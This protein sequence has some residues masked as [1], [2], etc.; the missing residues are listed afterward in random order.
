QD[1][2]WL[3]YVTLLKKAGSPTYPSRS[4]L[5]LLAIWGRCR[6]SSGRHR[7]NSGF[8]PFLRSGGAV[9]QVWIMAFLQDDAEAMSAGSNQKVTL[10]LRSLAVASLREVSAIEAVC[11]CLR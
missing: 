3:S 2:Y 7:A 5:Q 6:S 4:E 1:R 9:H 11:P 8:A 10:G